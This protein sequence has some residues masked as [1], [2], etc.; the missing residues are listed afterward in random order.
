MNSTKLPD[1]QVTEPWGMCSTLPSSRIQLVSITSA[2]L[3]CFLQLL[4]DSFQ[5][6][7]GSKRLV[8][9]KQL[10]PPESS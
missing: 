5:D 2:D 9:R 4:E 8:L 3:F 10:R 6:T 7:S 1:H